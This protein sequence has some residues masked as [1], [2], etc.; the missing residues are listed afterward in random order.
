[1]KIGKRGRVER[2]DVW[3][4]WIGDVKIVLDCGQGGA[5]CGLC[6]RSLRVIIHTD[7]AGI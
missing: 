7:V 2:N 5:T 4:K 3:G 6:R 1:M